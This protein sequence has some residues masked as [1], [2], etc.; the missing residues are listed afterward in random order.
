MKIENRLEVLVVPVAGYFE[1]PEPP[2]WLDGV[3]TPGRAALLAHVRDGD[4]LRGPVASEAT[5]RS[6]ATDLAQ[7]AYRELLGQSMPRT[8]KVDHVGFIETTDPASPVQLVYTVAWPVSVPEI[9]TEEASW[10]NLAWGEVAAELASEVRD[11][12]RDYWRQALEETP[13]V[14]S[15]LPKYFTISQMHEMY[16]ALWGPLDWG[17]FK[18]FAVGRNRD[19][20]ATVVKDTQAV[21]AERDASFNDLAG[22]GAAKKL[23]GGGVGLSLG[24]LAIPAPLLAAPAAMAAAIVSGTT[25]YQRSARGRAPEWYRATPN[26]P[27]Y[28]EHIFT[29]RPDW[30]PKAN[31]TAKSR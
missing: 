9:P 26:P 19:S 24:T 12:V 6:V 20:I 30:M 23:V 3:V 21:K 31:R 27:E 4:W 11:S 22:K 28:L 8:A 15:L 2:N 29:I 10:V 18:D 17:S 5:P 13:A 7:A 25:A 1:S 16:E 14:V